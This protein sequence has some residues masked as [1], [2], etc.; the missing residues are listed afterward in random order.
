[1][2]HIAFIMKPMGDIDWIKTFTS[3]TDADAFSLEHTNYAELS[4]EDDPDHWEKY[5]PPV[6]LL[7]EAETDDVLDNGKYT[8]PIA[9]YQRGEKWVCTK[10][11]S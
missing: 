7:F 8:R 10:A 6:V 4:P 1:M 2:V 5:D 3:E 9:I 11:N